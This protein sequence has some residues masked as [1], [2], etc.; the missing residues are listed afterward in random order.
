MTFLQR[1]ARQA[2]S[3]ASLAAYEAAVGVVARRRGLPA[4]AVRTVATWSLPGRRKLKHRRVFTREDAL[5]PARARQQA[6]YLAVTHFG[7]PMRAVARAAGID[8]AACSRAC[9]LVEEARSEA[10]YDRDLD[11]MQLEL[12]S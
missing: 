9:R 12:M 3:L 6:I 4:D 5:E 10:A 2:E 7:V 11:E 8:V 1:L